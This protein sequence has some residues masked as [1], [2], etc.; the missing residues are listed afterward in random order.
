MNYEKLYNLV[1]TF[2]FQQEKLFAI[3]GDID[4]LG[5]YVA[6]N[7][8]AKAEC[9]VDDYN[10]IINKEICTFCSE[11]NIR[12]V[13]L[14]SGEEIFGMGIINCYDS[15]EE[16]RIFLNTINHTLKE[17]SNYFFP[18]VT[19]S[20]GIID[21]DKTFNSLIKEIIQTSYNVVL[22][23]DF[24]YKIRVALTT[25]LDKEKFSNLPMKT[26]ADLIFYRNVVYTKM[27][28]YKKETKKLLLALSNFKGREELVKEY[29]TRYGI[30]D[31]KYSQLKAVTKDIESKFDMPGDFVS[32]KEIN[33]VMNFEHEK[34]Y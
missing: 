20:F 6:T 27:I 12:N 26:D 29:G 4:N 1:R 15:I 34:I 17:K 31:K 10:N 16:I 33:D 11:H 21:I 13:L 22:F 23:T 14:L 8:R 9:L 32:K 5:L 19:I 18:Y 2:N 3:T 24:I 28:Q 7:G 30:D 25:A